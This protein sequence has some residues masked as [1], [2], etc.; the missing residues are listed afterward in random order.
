MLASD[1]FVP[2]IDAKS[3]DL[4]N[5]DVTAQTSQNDILESCDPGRGVA[6]PDQQGAA[7]D[8]KDCSRSAELQSVGSLTVT[9]QQRSQSREFKL[10]ERPVGWRCHVCHLTC[11][12]LQVFQDHMSGPEH[13]KTL[14]DATRHIAQNTFVPRLSRGLQLER[15]RWC[16]TCQTHFGGNVIV[17]RRTQQHKVCKQRCRPFCPVCKRYF[18]TP[19]KFVEHMK[20]VEHKKQVQQDL[21]EEELI[22]VDAVGCFEGEQ[23]ERKVEEGGV[24]VAEGWMNHHVLQTEDQPELEGGGAKSDAAPGLLLPVSGFLCSSCNK[25]F[26]KQ[27]AAQ[28]THLPLQRLSTTEEQ[29]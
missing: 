14:K 3:S 6:G 9:I 26:Y 19:R 22:T 8:R 11:D 5:G 21:Q 23:Q 27:T 17:H 24:E 2:D 4:R 29:Q 13:L 10:A 12:S 16:D 20:S 7:E 15:Q 1:C 25:F 18:R 28:H